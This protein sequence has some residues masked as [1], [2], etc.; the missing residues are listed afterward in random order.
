MFTPKRSANSPRLA[1]ALTE[2]LKQ[3]T[4]K[5]IRIDRAIKC[6]WS[7]ARP[8]SVASLERSPLEIRTRPQAYIACSRVELY[9]FQCQFGGRSFS[10]KAG[11]ALHPERDSVET[12]RKIRE[13]VGEYI[14]QSQYQQHPT[15]REGDMIKP[16]WFK[17]YE[18]GTLPRQFGMIIQSWDTANN[19][20]ELNDYSVCTT[21][22]LL[23]MNFYLLDVYRKRLSYPDLKRA[24]V[25]SFASSI[26]SEF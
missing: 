20:G 17:C 21:W 12:Y 18:S 14:F 13:S 23:H 4:Q 8:G 11:D 15:A 19:C 1:L 3:L 5:I 22:G 7:I 16:E 10:R 9:E 24:V 26:R 25:N 2:S 6:S